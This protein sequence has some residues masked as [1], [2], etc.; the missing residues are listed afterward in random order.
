MPGTT[1]ATWNT[2]FRDQA[3]DV[4]ANLTQLLLKCQVATLT[5][6]RSAAVDRVLASHGWEEYRRDNSSDRIVWDPEIWRRRGPAGVLE[7]H[8]PGPGKFLPARAV[9]WVTLQHRASGSS[10][11]MIASHVTSGYSSPRNVPF[12]RWRDQAARKHLLAI[13]EVSARLLARTGP[14]APDYL[15][16]A[17][18]LNG[19]PT[20]VGAW[21]YPARLLDSLYV[22]DPEAGLDYLLHSRSSAERGLRVARRWTEPL[23]E[24]AFHPAHYK[25]VTFVTASRAGL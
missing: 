9:S 8:G 5:E 24:E 3:D 25:R 7:V 19:K 4:A 1:L 13:V 16:L 11:T 18:D 6:S 15:H 10:H 21:W 23:G 12:A 17:G 2:N 20:R 22:P 14:K